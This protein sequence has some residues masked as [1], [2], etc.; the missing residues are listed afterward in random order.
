MI[1]YELVTIHSPLLTDDQYR[2]QIG[3]VKD[4][5]TH[6]GG[7]I[8]LEDVWGKRRLAYQLAKQREGNYAVIQ[9][10]C[11]PT[12]QCLP[13]LDRFC[14]IE[15]T[16]LRFLV[17]RAVLNKSL[18][19]PVEQR[20]APAPEAGAAP[21]APPQK[22]APKAAD[23]MAAV[24]AAGTEIVADDDMPFPTESADSNDSPEK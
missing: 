9:F 20:P 11:P 5:I 3:R 10:D 13:E 4:V 22:P 21:K 2:E 7:T 6:N 18:G 17:T 14:K 12:A 19:T 1:T 15:E 16:V 23:E 8:R 24:E